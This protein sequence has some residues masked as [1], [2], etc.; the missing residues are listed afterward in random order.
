[1]TVPGERGR[2][3]D[4]N[5]KVL[6]VSE[7]AATVIATPYQVKDPEGT[8]ERLGRG[9]ARRPR[10]TSRTPSRTPSRASPTWPR[11]S[12]LSQAD[13][14]EELKIDGISTLPDSRRLYPQGALAA[15]VIGAVGAENEGLTGL[16]QAPGRHARRRQ[17]RAGGRPRRARRA[18][19]LRHDQAGERRRGS[20]ADDRRRD[21]GPRRGGDRRG[22]R[23]VLGRRRQRRRHGPRDRRRAG[24]G[25]LARLRPERAGRGRARAAREPRDRLHLRARLDLQG[26][27]RRRRAGGGPG[28]SGD[29]L[30]PALHASGR[31]PRDRGGARAPADRR[32]RRRDPRPVLE[33]RRGHDRARGRRREVRRL[34]PPL[35][36]RRAD[37]RRLPRRGAGHPASTSTTTR[38]RPWATCRS[39]RACR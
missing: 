10:S 3:L 35:R 14:V 17:R 1:M 33:R 24:D 19:P 15:Q 20:A 39:A 4:R 30:P 29:Q 16:E 26:V 6:A 34:D 32:D 5:G 22:R 23:A 31:R 37:R 13:E 2:V 8:A 28:D 36:L 12:S 27:H 7:D 18:D 11:R 38:V 21:P 25:Q 9:A